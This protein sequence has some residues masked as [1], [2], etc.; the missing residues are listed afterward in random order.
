MPDLRQ[1]PEDQLSVRVGSVFCSWALG[2]SGAL[3]LS[4]RRQKSPHD[5]NPIKSRSNQKTESPRKGT[6]RHKTGRRTNSELLFSC[7]AFSWPLFLSGSCLD[8]SLIVRRFCLGLRRQKSPHDG[9]PIKSRSNQK[10]ASP[11]K[12]TKKHKKGRRTTEPGFLI[13]PFR[14]HCFL[15]GS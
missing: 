8:R 13:V 5:G 12:G 1:Q 11:R 3:C 10:T 2:R 14:G 4:L 9:N 6:K 15:S 7:C